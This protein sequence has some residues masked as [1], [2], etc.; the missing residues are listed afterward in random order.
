MH[1]NHLQCTSETSEILETSIY[2]IG[3]RGRDRSISAARVGA[4]GERRHASATN[5]GRARGCPW[6]G[7]GVPQHVC[8]AAIG[9]AAAAPHDGEV[10][11]RQCVGEEANEALHELR[12]E[13]TWSAWVEK[14]GSGGGVSLC[15]CRRMREETE[16]WGGRDRMGRFF[17]LEIGRQGGV[18]SRVQMNARGPAPMSEVFPC[19]LLVQLR[20]RQPIYSTLTLHVHVQRTDPTFLEKKI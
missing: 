13:T 3:W 17:F 19:F 15:C 5:T 8:L 4:G 6:L 14:G 12:E 10:S 18:G 9:R 7:R 16:R 2:N 11:R 20:H 1:I